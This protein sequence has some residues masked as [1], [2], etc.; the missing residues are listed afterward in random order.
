[1]S[2]QVGA[3]GLRA[4][5]PPGWDARIFRRR[6][7]GDGSTHPVLHAA[8]FPLPSDGGDFG[9]GAVERMGNDDV[10]VSLVEYHPD[11]ASTPLFRGRGFP[12]FLDPADFDPLALQRTIPGHAGLQV[13][14]SH[15][16]RAFCL[17]VVLGSHLRRGPL[18]ALANQLLA[19]IDVTSE[20]GG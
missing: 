4:T 9:S 13:F 20:G 18:V 1:M 12:R 17:Y 14:C 19:G 10:F 8:T 3:H 5:V 7:D 11:A 2:R 16:G 15:R 6:E